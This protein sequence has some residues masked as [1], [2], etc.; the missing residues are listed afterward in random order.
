[1]VLWRV[2]FQAKFGK[3]NELVAAFKAMSSSMA[4][5]R[6]MAVQ[7]RIL[8]DIS[9]PFDT[10]VLETTHESLAALEEYRKAMFASPEMAEGAASGT[11]LILSGRNEYYTIEA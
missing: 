2:I 1:M 9:G 5:E 11:D 10:V 3:A 6:V 4:G 7:P 8:T